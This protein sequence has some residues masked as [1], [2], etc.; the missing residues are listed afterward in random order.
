[1]QHGADEALLLFVWNSPIK[2][3]EGTTQSPQAYF[4]LPGAVE[5]LGGSLAPQVGAASGSAPTWASQLGEGL[6]SQADLSPA[7]PRARHQVLAAHCIW[8]WQS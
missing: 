7:S 6:S 4:G 3:A 2:G 1:M 8:D 5:S